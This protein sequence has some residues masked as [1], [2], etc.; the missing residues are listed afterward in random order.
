MS[1]PVIS[2]RGLG[3]QYRLGATHGARYRTLR[4]VIAHAFSF[5]RGERP[6][7]NE[8][9]WALKGVSF[10]VAQGE[11][12]GIIGRN[13]AG[14]TTL[15]KMLSRITEPTTGEI[16]LRGR[17]ASLLEVG[18]GFHPELTGREN[19][20]L[21]GAIL[22][23]S[24]REI[25]A[26]FD[27]II[28]F[29]GVEKFID[30]PLKRYSSGMY[31]RLAFAVAAHLDSDILLVDEVLAVGDAEFQSKCRGKMG[32]VARW[33]RT[34]LFVS[35]NMSSVLSLCSRGILLDNGR[36]AFAA[37]IASCVDRYLS[38]LRVG[39]ALASVQLEGVEREGSGLVRARTLTVSGERHTGLIYAGK[40]VLFKLE[41]EANTDSTVTGL[42]VAIGIDSLHGERLLTLFTKFDKGFSQK[43]LEKRSAVIVCRIPALP[44]SPGRYRLTAWVERLGEVCDHVK[45]VAQMTVE[46]DDFY[47]TGH[48]PNAAQGPFM[49]DQEWCWEHRAAAVCVQRAGGG[50]TEYG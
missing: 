38:E 24:R 15:L 17:V 28:D 41:L 23:M 21:N 33:G 37:P 35:H 6:A 42:N 11:V 46:N 18:T 19:I 2:V 7:R 5:R 27:E 25:R 29:A 16:V 26:R 1:E 9:F 8:A 4:D 45:D 32:E 43:A 31:V 44:L 34:V 3:K 40:P 50:L 39:D 10:D 47:G 14:K 22:G 13:G 12:L 30:T 20:F 49:V 48:V 36:I